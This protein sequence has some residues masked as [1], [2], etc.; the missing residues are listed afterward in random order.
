MVLLITAYIFCF[1]LLFLF[2]IMSIIIVSITIII[3]ITTGLKKYDVYA[4]ALKI[5]PLDAQPLARSLT[6][7]PTHSFTHSLTHSLTSFTLLLDNQR[8]LTRIRHRGRCLR[9]VTYYMYVTVRVHISVLAYRDKTW[10]VD[11]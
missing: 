10:A 5:L 3:T 4:L 7:P 9:Q 1:V 6:H 8:P 11:K 2:L